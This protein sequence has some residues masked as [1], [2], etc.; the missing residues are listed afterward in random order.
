[1]FASLFRCGSHGENR[2]ARLTLEVLEDRT[3]PSGIP[4]QELI[5][6]GDSLSDTGNVFAATG[7][8]IP[9]AFSSG[10]EPMPLYAEGR[11]SNGPLWVEGVA[12]AFSLPS[13]QPGVHNFAYG[14]ARTGEG[15]SSQGIPNIGSQISAFLSQPD[16]GLGDELVLLWGGGNNFFDLLEI[17]NP[18]PADV[19]QLINKTV[20]DIGNHITDLA[21][22]GAKYFVVP[23]IVPISATPA[24]STSP[25][26][27]LALIEGTVDALNGALAVQLAS[28]QASLSPQGV[29]IIPFDTNALFQE[30]L[31]DPAQFGF[32][33]VTLPVCPACEFGLSPEVDGP[34][35]GN[36][37]EFLFWDLIHPTT[38]GHQVLA[39]EVADA[40]F[41]QLDV[42]RLVVTS[43]AD[44]TDNNDHVLTLREAISLANRLPGAQRIDFALPSP[45]T[46]TLQQGELALADHLVVR[47]PG[48]SRLTISGGG[49]SRVFSVESDVLVSI[50]NVTITDGLAEHGGGIANAGTLS[51]VGTVV[52]G[53]TATGGSSAE[54]GGILNDAHAHLYVSF[55]SISNNQAI[56]SERGAGGG[57]ANREGGRVIIVGSCIHDNTARGGDGLGGGIFS[58]VGSQ[59]TLVASLIAGNQA[60]QGDEDSQGLGG[61]VYLEEGSVFQQW[62]S[63]VIGNFASTRGNNIFRQQ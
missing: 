57:I 6:F 17:E 51:L 44:V 20:T 15:F 47:G 39:E 28:L 38:A 56:G 37:D 24:L 19:V 60:L 53:N 2:G 49:S 23:N 13:P 33:N 62:W 5:V 11:F 22:A 43:P 54:G 30:I 9:P 59:L 27:V 25:P 10:A 7:G 63:P 34:L 14:G 55:S 48:A 40:L 32:S 18:G 41:S 4:F 12:E 1:M 35:L 50:R 16:P 21:N 29:E 3:V 46:I 42:D 58:E 52:A 31:D 61:G 36:P 26:E 8:L 45:S